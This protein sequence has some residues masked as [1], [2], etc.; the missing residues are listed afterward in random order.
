MKAIIV[1]DEKHVRQAIKLLVPWEE[2][3]IDLIYEAHDGQEATE[4]I[5]LHKPQ[6]IFTDMMMP[7]MDGL[8][9][10]EWLQTHHPSGKTIVIS[11]F[12]DFQLVRHTV[13]YGGLDYILKPI[14]AEQ[15]EAAVRKA[16]QCWQQ[17]EAERQ[18]QQQRNIEMN[19][20]RPVYWDKVLSNFIM[21][22][23][24]FEAAAEALSQEFGLDR[25]M[26]EC[27]LAI[28]SLETISGSLKRK[29]QSNLDLLFFSLTNICNEF[30]QQKPPQGIAYRYWNSEDEIIVLLYGAHAGEE[31]LNDIAN[32]IWTAFKGNLDIGMSPVHPFPAGLPFAYKQAKTALRH[33]NLLRKDNQLHV[34]QE[35]TAVQH[36]ALV[37][38]DYAEPIHLSVRS[39]S[40]VEIGKAVQGWIQAIGKLS[41]ISIEELEHW[42]HEYTVLRSRWLIE[43]F[44]DRQPEFMIDASRSDFVLPLD[45]EG[46]LS[47]SLWQEQLTDSLTQLSNQMLEHQQQDNNAIFEIAKY[48][49]N[50][51]HQDITL[52]EIAQHFYLSRE[53]ISRK[54]KQQFQ[55]NVSDYI[56][57]LRVDKAKLLLLNPHLKI[58][59]IAGMVGYDD[60]KYF[61]KVFKKWIGLSPNEYRKVSQL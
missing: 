26:K 58:A 25:D 15:L 60:E 45:D 55:I 38:T 7:L 20:I 11:G 61:S 1:D 8:K 41:T 16:A 32:G 24:G 13:Q 19:Q 31:L 27:R 22:P 37:F 34:Y 3:G 23:H 46:K 54:F 14:D 35:Q 36:P 50:H 9:L 21:E 59:Q 10:L 39:G 47:L 6:I 5:T 28:I 42:R 33:R 43:W 52:I 2:L 49:Q 53:Y 56:T 57:Q 4:L 48:I 12:D 51:Y 40:A 44:G 30:L 18:R 17:E 29:F